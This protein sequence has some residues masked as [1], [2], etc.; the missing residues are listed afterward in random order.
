M[1]IGIGDAV[2]NSY[3]KNKGDSNEPQLYESPLF[4]SNIK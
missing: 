3:I 1:P 2:D 4:F